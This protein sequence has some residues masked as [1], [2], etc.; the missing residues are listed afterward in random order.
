VV[1]VEG[2]TGMVCVVRKCCNIIMEMEMEIEMKKENRNM[3]T[4]KTSTEFTFP[5]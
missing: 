3:R 5:N 1:G 4:F 2:G